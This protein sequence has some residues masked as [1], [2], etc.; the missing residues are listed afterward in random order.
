MSFTSS[1]V[2]RSDIYKDLLDPET[3]IIIIIS[4][5]AIT[6]NCIYS[7]LSCC[8]R[9]DDQS[10]DLGVSVFRCVDRSQMPH[11]EFSIRVMESTFSRS[12]NVAFLLF[13]GWVSQCAP[14]LLLLFSS[15]LA[16]CSVNQCKG[17]VLVD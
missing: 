10:E 3:S 1:S 6:K 15:I 2:C 16:L 13:K 4:I 5:H 7:F 8:M 11:L 14:P 17:N 12:V 9:L